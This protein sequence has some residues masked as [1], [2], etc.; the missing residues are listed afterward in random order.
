MDNSIKDLLMV[1]LRDMNNR[2]QLL[3]TALARETFVTPGGTALQ[4]CARQT[5]AELGMWAANIQQ[6]LQEHSQLKEG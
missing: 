3:E 4:R 2:V 6:V 5:I 1:H